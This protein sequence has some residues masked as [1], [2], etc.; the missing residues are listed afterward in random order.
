MGV[1]FHHPAPDALGI[2]LRVPRC[3]ERIREIDAAAVAA[4]FHH[5]W[6]AVERSFGLLGMRRVAHNPAE[7]HRAGFL[8][9]ERIGDIVLKEFTC[10]KA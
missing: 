9:V 2:K 4:H 6:A 3:I 7:M 10:A 5:L 8:G 1:Q